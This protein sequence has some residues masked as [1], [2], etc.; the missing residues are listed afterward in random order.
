MK[1]E[2]DRSGCIGCGLCAGTCPE[3]FEM[4][5]DGL[6]EVILDPIPEASQNAAVE[7]SEGCPVGVISIT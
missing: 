1:A 3:V 2:I 5:A 4:A 6:A 7:A